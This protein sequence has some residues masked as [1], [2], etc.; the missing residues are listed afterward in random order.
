MLLLP[1]APPGAKAKMEPVPEDENGME[2][3]EKSKEEDGE[4]D[5]DEMKMR[6]LMGLARF[7]TT[8]QKKV[9]GNDVGGV[10]EHKATQYRLYMYVFPTIPPRTPLLSKRAANLG[11]QESSRRV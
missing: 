1:A 7:G 5:D 10:Y 4:V 8:K 9:R 6:A 11:L 2:G 3:E